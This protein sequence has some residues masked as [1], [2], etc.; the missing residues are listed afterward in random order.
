VAF[1]FRSHAPTTV[2]KFNTT[3]QCKI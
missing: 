2:D 3:R 1:G